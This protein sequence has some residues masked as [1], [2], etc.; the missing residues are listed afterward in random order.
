MFPTGKDGRIVGTLDVWLTD[1]TDWPLILGLTESA[2]IFWA[3]LLASATCSMDST[4][5]NNIRDRKIRPEDHCLASQA[6]LSDAG[7]W[8]RGVDLSIYDT[9]PRWRLSY[10]D[11]IT[12]AFNN[13]IRFSDVNLNDGIR[14]IHYNQCISNKW[15]FSIFILPW[16]G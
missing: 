2:L 8:L 3:A 11:A 14:D 16:D 6:L 7:L 9:Y 1:T 5:I 13:F 15:E 4:V 12:V 10:C